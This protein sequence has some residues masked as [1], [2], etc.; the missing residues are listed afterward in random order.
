MIFDKRLEDI[1]Q[2]DLEQLVLDKQ[3]EGAKLDYKEEL[4]GNSESE[5]KE[6]VNDISSFANSAGGLIIYGIVE[7]RDSKGQ[8]SGTPAC[9]VGLSKPNFD[10]EELRLHQIIRSS[11]DPRVIAITMR[12]LGKFSKG[13]VFF[14]KVPKSFSA[15]H[16]VTIGGTNRFYGRTS[17]GKHLLDVRELRSAFL[18]SSDLPAK[19]RSFRQDRLAKIMS[20]E[21]PVQL[22]GEPIHVLHVIPMNGFTSESTF[23]I[24]EIEKHSTYLRPPGSGIGS[25]SGRFNLEGYVSTDGREN[26]NVISYIQVFRNGALEIAT[27]RSDWINNG[28]RYIPSSGYERYT[29]QNASQAVKF[30]KEFEIQPPILLIPSIISINK[31]VLITGN[32]DFGRSKPYSF[33]AEHVLLP[34]VTLNE[35]SQDLTTVLRPTFDALWQAGGFAR[36]NNY[37]T[38]GKWHARE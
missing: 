15:P 10:K 5:K 24:A 9:I 13:P 30:L 19:I 26:E 20:G 33:N 4:P 35:F 12:E 2:D 3:R 16:C 23:P 36:S 31:G 27:A 21:T 22:D 37:D 7:E 28:I 32:S 8:P 6:F 17:A 34:D 1:T 14:I 11:L 38:N 29:I 25:W 18:E